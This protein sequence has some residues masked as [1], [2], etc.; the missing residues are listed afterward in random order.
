MSRTYRILSLDGG[1]A[2]PSYLRMLRH[3]ERARPGFLDAVDMFAGTSDGAWAAVFLASRPKDMPALAALDAVIA[4][5]ERVVGAIR[6]GLVGVARLVSG[7]RSAIENDRVLAELTQACGVGPSGEPIKLGELN[8]DV[9]LVTFRVRTG[10]NK[11]GA[12][13]YHN[14]GRERPGHK[15]QAWMGDTEDLRNLDFGAAE[16]ALRSGSVPILMPVRDGHV[17]GGLFANNPSMCGL[18][19]LL[20]HRKLRDVD[21]PEDVVLLSC[22]ADQA[23]TGGS[24]ANNQFFNRDNVSWGWIA[25]LFSPRSPMLLLETVISAGGRGVAFQTHQFLQERFLRLALPGALG[26]GDELLRLLDGQ[27][28]RIF[29]AADR[30]AD[31]WAA[32]REGIAFRP[33]FH[34][35]TTWIKDHW[36]DAAPTTT[37]ARANRPQTSQST[38]T[39]N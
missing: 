3:I 35:T 10:A 24:D 23:S 25:W 19:Q 38:G 36:E 2:A 6:P 5:N 11:P 32:G 15:P 22:G 33:D 1:P 26:T 21:G 18:S 9:A 30:Q 31:Q 4:F 20:R 16:I 39:E 17:D 34:A 29:T 27:S 28:G 37:R 7:M 13:I 14:L 8:R 12:H